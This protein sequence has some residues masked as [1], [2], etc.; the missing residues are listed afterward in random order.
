LLSE[1]RH[2]GLVELLGHLLRVAPSTFSRL[3]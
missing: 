3:L 1:E 2:L